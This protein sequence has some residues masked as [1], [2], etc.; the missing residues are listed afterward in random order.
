MSGHTGVAN[1]LLQHGVNLSAVTRSGQTALHLA[2]CNGHLAVTAL[3]LDRPDASVVLNVRD[4]QGKLPLDL[5]YATK[6]QL[7]IDYF[8]SSKRATHLKVKQL[9]DLVLDLQAQVQQLSEDKQQGIVKHTTL[10]KV[11]SSSALTTLCAH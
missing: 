1:A 11:P 5:A 3:L 4:A 7:M 10:F 2:V 9:E 6:N 8:D